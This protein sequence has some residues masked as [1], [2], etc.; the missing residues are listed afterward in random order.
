MIVIKT[1]DDL[2]R[3][4]VSNRVAA[5]VRDQVAAWLR[6]GLTT[7]EIS[8]YAGDLI[9]QAGGECAFLGYRGFPGEICVS[10][11]DEV[12]HGI[13]GD[14]RV[15]IGDLV[16]LDIG[17]LIDGFFGDTA[18][19]VMVGVTN[20]EWIRLVRVTEQA[21]KAGI[22]EAMC[23]NRLSDISYAVQRVVQFAGFSV[24]KDYVGHGIGRALHE[25]PQVPNFGRP[26]KGVVLRSGM[27][28]AIEPMVNLGKAAVKVMD[29]GWTVRTRDHL[30]SAHFEHTVAIHP[31]G[32]EIL[33]I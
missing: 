4:R 5:K 23:G 1:H 29:D 33:T 2:E 32:P 13:P 24:V 27:T 20:P 10:V 3:M 6:P 17:V 26:G 11:N 12:V 25:D 21:L 19:T 28:L 22:A 18:T 30:P 7:G 31:D 16:S 9:R 14:R 8:G 15:E